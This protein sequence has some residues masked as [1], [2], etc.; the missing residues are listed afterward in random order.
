MI[1]LIFKNCRKNKNKSIESD[2]T[3]QIVPS[4]KQI[5]QE[6]LLEFDTVNDLSEC[7]NDLFSTEQH[8]DYLSLIDPYH[9]I[10]ESIPKKAILLTDQQDVTENNTVFEMVNLEDNI[11]VATMMINNRCIKV[12]EKHL[13][14]L[15]CPFTWNLEP[16]VWKTNI[17]D[18]VE[19]K[20]GKYNMNISSITFS[21]EK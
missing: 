20:Y 7:N 13:E 17:V 2:D 15:Q 21:F 19:N 18:H 12:T 1:W 8:F 16:D 6:L 10:K 5:V 3:K 11:E 9:E 14:S 4:S